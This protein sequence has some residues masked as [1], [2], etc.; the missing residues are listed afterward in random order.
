MIKSRKDLPNSRVKL[1]ITASNAQFKHAFEHELEAVAKDTKVEG[2]RPGKAPQAKVLQQVGRPRIE[3]A[4]LDHAISDAYFEALQEA[5]LVPVA[6][7]KVEVTSFTAP[8]DD[9]KADD[10]AVTFDIE[11]DV[12]PTVEVKGYEKIRVKMP[13]VEP[14]K[15]MDI[16][17][18]IAELRRQRA[19]LEPAAK[20]TKVENEM[21]AEIAFSGSVDG[22]K[23]EDM[24]SQAHPV[25]VGKGQLIPGFEDQMIGMKEKESKTF[26]I[27][28]PKDYHAKELAGKEA[29]FTIT[30]NELKAMVMPEIDDEFAVSYGQKDLKA[31]REMVE[32][33]LEDERKEKQNAELEE[34]ILTQLLKIAKVEAPASM[35]EQ[36]VDR[37]VAENKDR[38]ERMQVGWQTYLDQVNKTEEEVKADIR[39]QAERN[40]KIGLSLGKIIQEEKIDAK[41]ASAMREAMDKLIAIA[42][43]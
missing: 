14:V 26:K 25:V 24:Q 17:E 31:L 6:N 33:N 10:V 35:V 40:V 5:T 30:I 1:T 8:A 16:D 13:K 20:D 12:I 36:E 18:V 4:A 15:D 34:E 32:Q 27:T 9:A 42:T 3:A 21:W 43:K 38:F 39:P 29:E 37:V 28:F 11:V 22:V 7:P 2:F 41:D 23:R 19:K